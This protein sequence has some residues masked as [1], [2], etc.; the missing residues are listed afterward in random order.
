LS[1]AD[2]F[3]VKIME[4]KNYSRLYR[5]VH[6]SMAFCLLF[7]LLTIFLRLFWMNKVHISAIIQGFLADTPVNLSEEESI[8][9]AKQIRKPMWIWHS[10]VGYI[11]TGVYVIRL[12]VPLFGE[13]KFP[14]PFVK[15]TSFQEKFQTWVYFVFYCCLGVSLLTGLFIAFG[16][17]SLEEVMETIHVLS[18]YYLIAF[19]VLHFGG[20]LLAEFTKGKGI[21]SRIIS[22]S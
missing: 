16:P 18:I 6:W 7:M 15:R 8:V 5:L 3:E 20:V 17:E 12:I 22:G 2:E 4:K 14:N 21:I 1:F 9:L 11:L 13:M 10:Y 19:I